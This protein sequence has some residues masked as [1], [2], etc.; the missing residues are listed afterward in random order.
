M[1]LHLAVALLL[2][3]CSPF[4]SNGPVTVA[5]ISEQSSLPDDG[6]EPAQP[7]NAPAEQLLQA[8]SR[9]GLVALD[10]AG[11]VTSALAERWIVTDDGLSYIFRLRERTWPDGEPITAADVR[12]GLRQRLEELE[13]TSLGLDL[14]KL[15]EIRA[16]TEKVI[17]LRLVSP[18]P[19]FLRLLAQPELGLSQRGSGAGPM[20][21][22][23]DEDADLLRLSALPPQERG[24][25]RREDWEAASRPLE[26]RTM[27]PAGAIEAFSKGEVDLLLN[28]TLASFPLIELGPLSRGTIQV[29]PA[30]GVLGLAFKS[31]GGFFSEPER[32]EALSMAI[33]RAALI[34]PFGIGGWQPTSWIV[35]PALLEGEGVPPSRWQGLSMD[36]RRDIARRRVAA[37]RA[38]NDGAEA[39]VRVALPQGLGSD[40]IFR[41][42][43]EAWA[44][45]GVRTLRVPRGAGADLEWRDRLARYPS[46]RW[47]LNQFNCAVESGLCA[48][49]ADEL[50]RASLP[51]ADPRERRRLLAEAHAQLIEAEVF[52]PLGAPVRWSLV[53][54]S[55]A[56][57][58]PNP[59]GV[60]PLFPL[61]GPTT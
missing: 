11:E 31:D 41:G 40:L 29:D 5:I 18:M 9:E 34:A 24:L 56:N 33:D 8:A 27:P 38:Q 32:R 3:A 61:S 55:I 23:R 13:G 47:Y 1:C 58:Q 44:G 26:V 50:V 57:Y 16:M 2:G 42:L 17:E 35:P 14:A 59:W 46:P 15:V 37:W 6:S 60:H 22:S 21:V 45:I 19:D 12:G 20:V 43:A 4:D 25:P 48:E 53:R 10:P 7:D 49:T 28:G 30:Q 54:S 52:I 51:L 36:Q 39:V